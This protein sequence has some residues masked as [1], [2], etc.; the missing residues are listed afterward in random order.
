MV[1]V[2]SDI[3]GLQ[4]GLS[5]ANTEIHKAGR[6]MAQNMGAAA[7][8]AGRAMTMGL[9]LPLA[10][11]GYAAAKAATDFDKEMRNIQSISKQSE[12]SLKD[13][14]DAILDMSTD[15]SKTTDSAANLA[16][17]FYQIQS[18]GF[19]GAD[20]MKV[21]EAAAKA[22][23][24]GLTTTEVA[25]KGISAALNAY[26]M[27]ASQATKV[28]DILF[29]TV[30][31]GVLTFEE[32]TSQLGDIVSVGA[33][34]Q[35]PLEELGAAMATLTKAGITAP[36]AATGIKQLLLSFISPSQEAAKV[37][38]ALG[39]ELDYQALASKGLYGAMEDVY[40]ATG[41]NIE[42]MAALFPNVRALNAALA[43]TRGEM[44]PF[45]SDLDAL[46]NSAGATDAAFKEQTKSFAAA[47]ANFNQVM[48]RLKIELGNE[49]MPI[50]ADIAK[51]LLPVIKAFSDLP[52][53]TKKTIVQIGLF[54]A[55]LGP[56][57]MIAGPIVSAIGSIA[58]AV[59]AIAGALSGVVASIAAALGVASGVVVLAVALIAGAIAAVATNFLG[60]RDYLLQMWEY[61]AAVF[62]F[63]KT[64]IVG[65]FQFITGKI[66]W[67]EFT[68]IVGKAFDEMKQRIAKA[69]MEIGRIIETALKKL[70]AVASTFLSWAKGG[71][72]GSLKE[73][74]ADARTA[75]A[76][77]DTTT[78][79]VN[80][81]TTAI[82]AASMAA[83]AMTVGATMAAGVSTSVTHALTPPAVDFAGLG[84]DLGGLLGDGISSGAGS[85]VDAAVSAWESAI[86]SFVDGARGNL[87][88]LAPEGFFADTTAPG[89]NGPFENI[90]RALDVAV[91]GA[92]S[93]WAAQLGLDQESAARIVRD[94]QAGLMTAEVQALIDI[95]MLT[96]MIQK[97]QLGQ[98]MTSAFV[99]DVAR[100]AGASKGAVISALIP[101]NIGTS[102][103]LATASKDM[104][105]SLTS[106]LAKSVTS[107]W[108]EVEKAI[109]SST[110]T[111]STMLKTAWGGL[112]TF[113]ATT[114]LAILTN[115]RL[116]WE[117]IR[118]FI[119]TT[120]ESIR[121]NVYM[122][123]T[124]LQTFI[125]STN[126]AIRLDFET[127]WQAILSAVVNAASSMRDQ[128]IAIVNDMATQIRATLQALV[129]AAYQYGYDFVDQLA[130][131]LL[132]ASDVLTSA[133][134]SVVNDMLDAIRQIV[135][136]A[137][138]PP[139]PGGPVIPPTGG[140]TTP[141]AGG[142]PG[143]GRS[144]TVNVFNPT[145]VPTEM[146]VMRSMKTLAA[147]GVLNPV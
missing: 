19:A 82:T 102:P 144:V 5:Q 98:A 62:G 95:P 78:A 109:K 84:V 13:L 105:S 122:V 60:F 32:L 118:L 139:L 22:G 99:A 127:Q 143:A 17:G 110:E 70:G 33:R 90:F 91:N 89:G 117:A 75:A 113:L 25:A 43:L 8:S 124:A 141:P 145:G 36:E 131:G 88:G 49:L 54:V 15:M 126:A 9:T 103:A 140:E 14:G 18:S 92:N 59:P 61:V 51:S 72:K 23:S 45:A 41:G 121:I 38:H 87:E 20:A 47:M 138:P 112:K 11:I 1:K 27:D 146:S 42:V 65:F 56:I 93:Q 115:V 7:F 85:G 66:S 55:A 34:A 81:T 114:N 52:D 31:I 69:F 135:N 71:F 142:I 97:Q 106:G 116:Q 68:N 3:S 133:A 101:S 64:L 130:Q 57:L 24:A 79:A 4:R 111:T 40:K 63:L 67:K 136:D 37:A 12:A 108:G 100:A 125:V 16:A 53:P 128:T 120:L 96:G 83:S 35:V 73:I 74:A 26:G 80:R 58:G 76:A 94:F 134:E 44:K 129:D 50:L 30:D 137:Q 39:V 147:I 21:L 29:R 48:N 104:A 46:A 107:A 132:G 77:F 10:G 2:G 119:W 6:N 86:S 123:L 28:S